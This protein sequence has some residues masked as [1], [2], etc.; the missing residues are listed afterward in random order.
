MNYY[1]NLSKSKLEM[2]RSRGSSIP[3]P[4]FTCWA[5]WFIRFRDAKQVVVKKREA[6]LDILNKDCL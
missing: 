4:S 2:V 6:I 3:I 1:I 5:I